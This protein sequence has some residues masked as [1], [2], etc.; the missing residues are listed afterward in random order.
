MPKEEAAFKPIPIVSYLSEET[1]AETYAQ[2]KDEI[3]GLFKSEL[4][5]LDKDNDTE[6]QESDLTVNVRNSRE[7]P[8][9]KKQRRKITKRNRQRERG[10]L[11]KVKQSADENKAPDRNGKSISPVKND[12]F[13]QAM[14]M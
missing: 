9:S 3:A 8:M 1:E 6:R 11:R 14:S 7:K 5:A 12:D 4:A 2:I 13:E 10:T